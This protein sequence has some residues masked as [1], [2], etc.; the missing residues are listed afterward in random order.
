[1]YDGTI[2]RLLVCEIALIARYYVNGP[3][4]L[5]KSND[6]FLYAN[7]PWIIC[8]PDVHSAKRLGTIAAWC[9]VIFHGRIPAI[10]NALH[11]LVNGERSERLGI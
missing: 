2:D 9:F 6:N 11:G 8:V 1:V 5:L 3:A 7:V 10:V 4:S